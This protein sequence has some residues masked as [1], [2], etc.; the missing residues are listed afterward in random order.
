MMDFTFEKY[1]SEPA[2][3]GWGI[4]KF[5]AYVADLTTFVVVKDLGY[6][7]HFAKLECRNGRTLKLLVD[8]WKTAA[9][10]AYRF[11]IF[12]DD[13][14]LVKISDVEF[15]DYVDM[16]HVAKAASR[17]LLAGLRGGVLNLRDAFDDFS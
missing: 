7:F 17:H 12:A 13:D 9:E 4:V 11:V 14:D 10:R 8:D 1:V 5:R 16:D 3:I 6:G 2:A 15:H